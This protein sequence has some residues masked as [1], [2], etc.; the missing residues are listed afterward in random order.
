MSSGQRNRAAQGDPNHGVPRL[1][2]SV[3]ENDVVWPIESDI[4]R[5]QEYG[6]GLWATARS[7]DSCAG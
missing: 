6:S 5:A 7:P 3:G 2:N 4:V 1:A